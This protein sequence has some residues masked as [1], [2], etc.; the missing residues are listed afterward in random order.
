MK[1]QS[2]KQKQKKTLIIIGIAV[3]ALALIAG[4]IVGI[5]SLVQNITD[6]DKDKT[7]EQPLATLGIS[8]SSFPN[9][10]EYFVG[11]LSDWTG[12]RVQVVMNKQSETYFV[13]VND[14]EITGFDS[15]APNDKQ[16]ITVTYGEFSTTFTV[17]IKENPAEA[18]KRESLKLDEN[19]KST[20]TMD[21][22]NNT[23][24]LNRKYLIVVYTDGSEEKVPM[25]L[26][27]VV[28][29][30]LPKA[31]APGEISFT[32]YYKGLETTITVTIT[33]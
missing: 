2:S 8:I 23:S 22:W 15:S 29:G 26:N 5:V 28:G 6:G 17:K 33:E 21:E 10:M 14:V 16:V 30:S 24:V 11:E 18:P 20:F 12:L 31:T 19:F 32:I 25:S 3:L 1:L 13:G 7:P 9:K 4:L 27:Y